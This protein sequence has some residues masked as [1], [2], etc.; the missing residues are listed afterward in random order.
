M[1]FFLVI[2]LAIIVGTYLLDLIIDILNLKHVRTDLPKEFEG[3]YDAE[4]YKRSQEYLRENTR[5]G[6]LSESI[7]MPITVTFILFGGFNIVDGFARSFNLGAIPTGLIFAGVLLFAFQIFSI[8]FSVYDTFVIEEKYGFNKTKPRTFVLDILKSW[9]LASIIGGIVFSGVVWFFESAGP[10]AWLY[11]WIAVTI[12]QVFLMFVAPVV[13]M[14]LF[15]KFSPLDEG[16]L[17]GCIEAYANSQNFKMKGVFTMDGSKRSTKSNAF[18][19][20]FGRFRRIVLLDTLIEKHTIEELISILAHEIG[21]YKKKHMLKSIIMSVL[22]TGLMF[23]ILSLF[24]KNKALF[25]AFR[26]EEISVYASLFFFGFLYAPIEMVLSIFG[27]MVS[28][29]YEYDADTFSVKTYSQ[30]NAM[31]AALKRLSVENL[32]NLNPH[33]LKVFFNY[34]HPPILKRIEFIRKVSP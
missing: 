33:P 8:P 25:A 18:L 12:F 17:R 22:T 20:G 16:K 19:T 14:P 13:I 2:I 7:T 6:I 26:M 23:L 11:C 31:I 9:L 3:Y 27:N 4:K 29:K 15:N 32:S 28:R 1:N 21:H 24:M 30:P 10:W 34:S 5:F